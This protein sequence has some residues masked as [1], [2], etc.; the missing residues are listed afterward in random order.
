MAK[1]QNAVKIRSQFFTLRNNH[2]KSTKWH[3]VQASSLPKFKFAIP[4]LLPDPKFAIGD[5][6]ADHWKDEFDQERIEVGVVVG[7]C[8]HPKKHQWEYLVNWLG[9]DSAVGL[10]PCFDGQL[11]AH[12]LGNCTLTKVK[13]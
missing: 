4:A 1:I 6:V 11:I 5:K 7:I 2:A 9:G 8:W 10:Y 12:S 13:Q 3:L